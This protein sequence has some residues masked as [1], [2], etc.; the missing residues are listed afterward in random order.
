[1]RYSSSMIRELSLAPNV[2]LSGAHAGDEADLGR[3][4]SGSRFYQQGQAW[5]VAGTSSNPRGERGRI[6]IAG[7]D[8]VEYTRKYLSFVEMGP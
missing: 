7:V 8:G 1:M 2:S 5:G 3:L 6:I 4:N